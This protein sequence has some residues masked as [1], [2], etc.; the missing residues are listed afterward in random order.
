MKKMHKKNECW[1]LSSTRGVELQENWDKLFEQFVMKYIKDC[2]KLQLSCCDHQR[3]LV[4]TP[5]VTSQNKLE[6]NCPAENTQAR[7]PKNNN[8][9]L[10][11][12]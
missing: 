7:T 9:N 11:T 10:N 5:S 2:H 1:I 12:G 3:V 6:N 8:T 4:E